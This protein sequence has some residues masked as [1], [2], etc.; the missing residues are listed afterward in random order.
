MNKEGL[1]EAIKNS[2]L[3]M[4]FVA[5]KGGMSRTAFW[6]KMNGVSEFTLSEIQTLAQLLG[7]SPEQIQDIFFCRNVS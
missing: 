7:L 6:R 5:K 3:K 1:M 4:E 2:G